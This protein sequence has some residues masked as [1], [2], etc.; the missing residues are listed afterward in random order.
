MSRLSKRSIVSAIKSLVKIVGVHKRDPYDIDSA[1]ASIAI[2]A[3]GLTVTLTLNDEMS[4][5][6]TL[7]FVFKVGGTPATIASAVVSGVTV[8]QTLAV[9]VRSTDTCTL[10]YSS[11]TGTLAGGAGALAS[12]TGHAITNG[13]TQVPPVVSSATVL[14]DGVTLRLVCSQSMAGTA[15]LGFTRSAGSI[16][17][18]S[19]STANVDLVIPIV[20]S[21]A[22]VG[23][24]DYSSATGD[25]AGTNFDLASFTA[26][27]ITNN[28]TQTAPSGAY[29]LDDDGTIA[30]SFGY[31]AM[32]ATAPA[33]RVVDY[34]TVGGATGNAAIASSI[35]PFT[36]GLVAPAAG[37][38]GFGMLIS[39]IDAV[40]G[41]SILLQTLQWTGAAVT[42]RVLMKTE[43]A[44]GVFNYTFSSGTLGGGTT[45]DFTAAITP[46]GAKLGIVL[47][48]DT[49]AIKYYLNG[50]LIGTASQ[51]LDPAI[52]WFPSLVATDNAA[53]GAGAHLNATLI[54]DAADLATYVP[55]GVKDYLDNTI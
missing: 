37:K 10:D 3:N 28:S 53:I 35:A 12:F 54:L 27:A 36:T 48:Y 33:Y 30:A 17:S 41:M 46:A 20:Y 55:A 6:G 29:V 34:T 19:I 45:G 52:G 5:S 47:E 23:T 11:A 50:T 26:M 43:R 7:G 8:V 31:G 22:S 1:V 13:S 39:A 32:P 42:T 24:L 15:A 25:L 14:A 9:P 18:G 44:A 40:D 16:T 51:A 2:A 4:G 21:G 38:V 49:N